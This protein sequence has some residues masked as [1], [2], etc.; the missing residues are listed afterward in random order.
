MKTLTEA[1][2]ELLRSLT[3]DEMRMFTSLP[4]TFY[5]DYEWSKGVFLVAPLTLKSFNITLKFCLEIDNG[6]VIPEV[7]DILNKIE[8]NRWINGGE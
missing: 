7:A 2:I 6:C 5:G 1:H 8:L 3:D 4:R